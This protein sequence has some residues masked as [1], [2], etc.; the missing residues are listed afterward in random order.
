MQDKGHGSELEAPQCLP[1][2][3]ET[4][5]GLLR[6]PGLR[7]HLKGI[8]TPGYPAKFIANAAC[9]K[10]AR[11][12]EGMKPAITAQTQS[13]AEIPPSDLGEVL[14]QPENG[15][16]HPLRKI[17]GKAC[18]GRQPY[19]SVHENDRQEEVL[20]LRLE[21]CA[22]K[23]DSPSSLLLQWKRI[24]SSLHR[25]QNLLCWRALEVQGVRLRAR[26]LACTVP[27]ED[28]QAGELQH[29]GC[30]GPR[31][32]VRIIRDRETD[33]TTT[34]SILLRI[35]NW[36]LRF[37]SMFGSL[38]LHTVRPPPFGPNSVIGVTRRT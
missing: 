38:R 37:S 4:P 5:S 18:P 23:S 34:R 14:L 16:R 11:V 2:F 12:S 35:K 3:S 17:H 20:T 22:I 7:T 6:G 1:D 8:E 31:E 9:R 28:F 19:P 26:R 36:R 33:T 27:C 29:R 10:I 30:T 25:A 24:I 13:L 32:Q 15:T 21:R